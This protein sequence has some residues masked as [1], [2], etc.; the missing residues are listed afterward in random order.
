MPWPPDQARAILA[1]C[2]KRKK[3]GKKPCSKHTIAEAHASL[4]GTKKKD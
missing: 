4:R 1:D 2:D 3:Q